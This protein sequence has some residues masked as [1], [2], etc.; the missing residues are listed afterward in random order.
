[1]HMHLAS[2]T[3]C[4]S[5]FFSWHQSF[6]QALDDQNSRRPVDVIL[7]TSAMSAMSVSHQAQV[8]FFC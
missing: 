1:M 4:V 8:F 5:C 7:I 6:F 2:L 3:V